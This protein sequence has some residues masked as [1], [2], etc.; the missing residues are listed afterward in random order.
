MINNEHSINNTRKTVTPTPSFIIV[1][2]YHTGKEYN[3]TLAGHV[4]NYMS[5]AKTTYCRKGN[6]C[7]H[8][9]WLLAID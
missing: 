8:H 7:W 5:M 9:A 6:E 3:I 1:T 4:D 2:L